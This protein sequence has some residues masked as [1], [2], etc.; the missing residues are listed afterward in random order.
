MDK[1]VRKVYL[2]LMKQNRKIK[3]VKICETM[4]LKNAFERDAIVFHPFYTVE[5]S[6]SHQV[7]KIV[8]SPKTKWSRG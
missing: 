4:I 3:S 8:L 2:Y 6:N 5:F 1:E 7:E